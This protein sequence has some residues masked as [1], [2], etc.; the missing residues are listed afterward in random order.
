[1][2]GI[3]L[4]EKLGEFNKNIETLFISGYPEL[5]QRGKVILNNK[6]FMSKPFVLNELFKRI[7]EIIDKS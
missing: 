6:N 4:F 1:M 5:L 2:S 7:R 3:S